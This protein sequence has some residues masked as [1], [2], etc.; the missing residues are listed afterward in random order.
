M[1]AEPRGAKVRGSRSSPAKEVEV[2]VSVE[3]WKLKVGGG[4]QATD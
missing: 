3:L 4:I 2:E 1:R